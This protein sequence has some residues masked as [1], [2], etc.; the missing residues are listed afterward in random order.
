LGIVSSASTYYLKLGV[1][2]DGAGSATDSIGG[3]DNAVVAWETPFTG[4][5]TE[6]DFGDAQSSVVP[7][8]G[9][10]FAIGP[11][12]VGWNFV[13]TPLVGDTSVPGVF[14]DMDG[15]TT[16]TMLRYYDS[17]DPTDPWKVWASFLPTGVIDLGNLD[18]EKGAW[19]F[20]PDAPSQG[21]GFIRVAG[22]EP[23]G[24]SITLKAGWNMVGYP[25]NDDSS[26]DVDDLMADT[27]ATGVM[28][29][30]PAMP[31][32]IETLAGNYVLKRGEAYWINVNSDTVW[33]VNW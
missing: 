23:A 14:T 32:H 26:Y 6:F 11:L 5:I 4:F 17:S 3:F 18:H 13:S 9:S 21:D 30:N 29:F 8:F 25:A 16:W 1:W 24:T 31:Y 7:S 19:L 22:T 33:S 27:G 20:I 2:V 28:G 10:M 12:G 15:D